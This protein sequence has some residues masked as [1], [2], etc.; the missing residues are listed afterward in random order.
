MRAAAVMVAVGLVLGCNGAPLSDAGVAPARR[1]VAVKGAEDETALEGPARVL[2]GPQAQSVVTPPL[3]ATV[4]QIRVREGDVVTAGQALVEVVMPELLDA[5]GRY[6]GG[7]V[8]L[9]AWTDRHKQ[10]SELRAQGLAR[11]AEVSEAAA[12]A[13][14]AR[15]DQQ[16]ARAVLLSAGVKESDVPGLLSGSG[17]LG[18]KAPASGVVTH[19]AVTLGESR[20]PGAGPLVWISSGGPVRLEA[21]F[22]RPPPLAL[23]SFEGARVRV[24]LKVLARAP[25]ADPKD[26]SFL[27]WFEPAEE[28]PL[29]AGSLGR[30]FVEGTEG[31][32]AFAV[33][34]VAVRRADGG[35]EVLTRRGPVAVGVRRCDGDECVVQGAL[36]PSDEVAVE[37]P[38]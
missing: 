36:E 21:R 11:S 15:A 12:R 5:A 23:Y 17:A 34:G 19:V 18:L 4:T 31:P 8:R 37:P 7:R 32:T 38:P 2:P 27:A 35:N 33:P 30:V 29:A 10:L 3:R 13:A 22:S 25:M 1:W 6:E 20:E 28:V 16:A 24:R 9:A 14:E 26:G